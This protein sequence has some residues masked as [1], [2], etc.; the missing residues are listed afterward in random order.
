MLLLDYKGIEFLGF[1]S[2]VGVRSKGIVSGVD[3]YCNYGW[4]F[5]CL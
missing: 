4:L 5:T 3:F 1:T 2:L